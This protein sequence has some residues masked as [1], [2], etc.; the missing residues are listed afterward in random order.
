MKK[1][2][3]ILAGV[4]LATGLFSCTITSPYAVTEHP[5]GKNKGVSKT[6]VIL[7]TIQLNKDYGIADA[8]R[9]GRIQ[10]PISTVDLKIS[11]YVLFSTKELIVTEA[12]N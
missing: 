11:N 2:K 10:G 12:E 3:G 5:I 7:G 9:N 4:V 6:T 8:A 1:I